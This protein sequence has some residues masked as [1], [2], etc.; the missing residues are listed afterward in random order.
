MNELIKERDQLKAENEKLISPAVYE[1]LQ[2]SIDIQVYENQ[3]LRA[4]I[5]QLREAVTYTSDFCL[6][7]RNVDGFDYG[8]MHRHMGKPK[9]GSRWLTPC[10]FADRA[11]AQDDEEAKR[12][13]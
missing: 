11:L 8:D 3:K 6:C 2:V 12:D 1:T 7:N 10:D 13:A 4:R 9:P 5:E